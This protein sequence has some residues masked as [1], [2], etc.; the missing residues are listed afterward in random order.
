MSIRN[1]VVKRL[2][3]RD[4]GAFRKVEDRRP[5]TVGV[6]DRFGIFH[7][8]ATGETEL[9]LGID[10]T[11]LDVRVSVLKRR[12]GAGASYV[13]G[14]VVTIHNVLGRLYMIP[15]AP[16]HRLIVRSIMRRAGV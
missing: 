8:L 12:D 3:L 15:V 11:H 4:V 10:D 13:L 5:R 16:L 14:S 9:V 2:G 6:G 1:Q 7:V